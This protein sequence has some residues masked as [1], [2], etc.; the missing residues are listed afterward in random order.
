ME[1]KS[2]VVVEKIGADEIEVKGEVAARKE[3]VV[4]NQTGQKDQT[5]VTE[6]EDGHQRNEKKGVAETRSSTNVQRGI[7]TDPIDKDQEALPDP[8]T[9]RRKRKRR[10]NPRNSPRNKLA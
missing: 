2:E 7:E 4:E 6:K 5:G 3:L 9:K 10:E 1:E 8:Q